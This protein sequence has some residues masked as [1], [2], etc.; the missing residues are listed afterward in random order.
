[1]AVECR[2]VCQHGCHWVCVSNKFSLEGNTFQVYDGNKRQDDR[3]AVYNFKCS[4]ASF[5]VQ[6]MN[7]QL[8]QSAD[9]FV[10]FLQ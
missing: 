5:K 3:A 7:V 9:S 8:Q 2:E 1:M 10:D 6:V 4:D